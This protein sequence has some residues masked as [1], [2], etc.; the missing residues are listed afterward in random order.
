MFPKFDFLFN[1]GLVL[2][3]A[4]VGLVLGNVVF[5]FALTILGV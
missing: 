5:H 3:C 1:L 4:Y 2:A